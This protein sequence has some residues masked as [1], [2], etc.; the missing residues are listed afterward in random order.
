MLKLFA[1]REKNGSGV[2]R[3]KGLLYFI[4]RLVKLLDFINY[5]QELFS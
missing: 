2:G 3:R 4:V 5:V 1:S